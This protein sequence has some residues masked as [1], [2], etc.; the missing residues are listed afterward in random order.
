MLIDFGAARQ[1][2]GQRHSRSVTAVLT[3]GYAP[4]E[5]YS[6]KGNQGPW[7]DVYA[8]GAVAYWA[9]G[10]GVPDD[11][12]E[13][14][15]RDGLRPL[16]EAVPGQVSAEL[17][18]AVDSALAVN[19]EDRPQSLEMWRALLE[20]RAGAGGA[21]QC[22]RTRDRGATARASRT[23]LRRVPRASARGTGR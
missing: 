23:C 15:R 7:T 1:A 9:L 22:Q 8:L 2:M 17:A 5:Q 14:V 12:T 10:G 20:G 6:A 4:I 11:A 18:S 13:R 3:P 16:A 19:E 21:G